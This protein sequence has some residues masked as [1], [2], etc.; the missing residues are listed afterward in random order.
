VFSAPTIAPPRYS[1]NGG[2]VEHSLHGVVHHAKTF[3]K[4]DNTTVHLQRSLGVA[5]SKNNAPSNNAPGIVW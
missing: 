4:T 3:D 5:P 2:L 1:T